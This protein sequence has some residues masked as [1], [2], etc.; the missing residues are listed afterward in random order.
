MIRRGIRRAIDLALSREDRW[1]RDVEEEIKL[2]LALRAE[3]L[4]NEGHPPTAAYEEAVRRFGP[5]HESRARLVDAARHREVRMRR[6]E[7][8]GDLGQDLSFALRTLVRGKVWTTITISTLALGIGATTAVFSVVSNL[9]LHSVPYPSPDRIVIIDQQ[10]RGGNNTG[11]SISVTSN[12]RVARS[13]VEQSKSFERIEAYSENTTQL[14]DTDGGTSEFNTAAV[15]PT[16]GSFAGRT[17][18]IGRMFTD[19]EAQTNARVVLLGESIWRQRF[20]GDQ[21][22]LGRAIWLGDSLYTIIGVAPAMMRMP[23][24]T[25]DPVDGWLPLNLHDDKANVMLVGR[26]RPGLTAEAASRELNAIADRV[27]DKTSQQSGLAVRVSSP[28]DLLRFGD[29]LRLLAVAVA[30]VLLVACANV[31]HLLMTRN[32]ARQRELAVRVALG[33]GR[34]RLLRQLVTESLLVTG[35]ATAAGIAIAWL[36][37]RGIIAARPASLVELRDVHLDAT[38]LIAALATAIV[39]GL[40]FGTL[41]IWQFAHGTHDALKSG[42]TSVSASKRGDR[43]RSIFVI[44]E[45]AM[46]AALLV[47]AVL[48]VRSV[49]HLQQTDIGIKPHGLYMMNLALPASHYATP[50]ARAQAMATIAQ[51]IEHMPGVAAMS[52]ASTPPGWRAFMIGALEAEGDTPAPA[53]AMGFVDRNNVQPTFFATTGIKLLEGST[54]TDTSAQSDQVIVNEGFAYSR[55]THGSV[56]GHRI[57]VA[58]HGT[59]DW[60]RIVGVVGNAAIGGP[61]T[62]GKKP[63]LYMPEHGQGATIMVRAKGESD[64]LP[65]LRDLIRQIDPAIRLTKIDAMDNVIARSIDAPRFVMV[66]LSLFT[67]LAVVLAMIG[68]YGVMSYMVTQRTREIGI[69]I[70]LG[71]PAARVARAVIARGVG[72]AAIG[73]VLGLLLSRW[74]GKLIE[75]QL[76]GVG[77]SDPVSFILG[78]SALLLTAVLAC[79]I[80]TRRALSVDPI[81]AIRAD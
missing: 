37:L 62:D 8:F 1:A 3:Q 27:T 25:S 46:S 32:A 55:W 13:F 42:A 74:G 67:V 64:L 58:F 33:A 52:V 70:A 77:R 34:M 50:A 18:I 56:L 4:M 28:S 41:G 24:V 21:H 73:G 22:V 69:R 47:G 23:R 16:F 29:T 40:V 57:R 5:L 54:F 81:T 26:L 7:L 11:M 36:G 80:P 19:D 49:R 30:L 43:L 12:G 76:Y 60:K 63:L 72:L 10:P 78:A 38:A 17:P 31:A 44:S 59:G 66:L 9:L 14:R 15:A 65:A 39:I 2:H 45:M 75:H 20:G 71:A 35:A 68:L 6:S 51:Q 48:L 79:I 61:L 53:D